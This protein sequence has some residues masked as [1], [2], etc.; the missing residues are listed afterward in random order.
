MTAKKSRKIY[1]YL[2]VVCLAGILV[3][4]VIDGYLGVYDTIYITVQ[5]REHEVD[6]DYWQRSRVRDYGYSTRANWGEPVHFRHEV[7]NRRFSGYSTTV[8]VSVWKGGT[9]I[10]ELLDR[11]ISVGAFDK[12]TV[13]WTLQPGELERSGFGIGE[14]TV[15]VK[16]GGMERRIIVDFHQPVEMGPVYPEK[17]PPPLPGD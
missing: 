1:L 17:V 2:S 3:I 9:E 16:H 8:E 12:L 4:F 6:P 15:K 10:I 14:Y 13:D 5:E 7:D 11:T